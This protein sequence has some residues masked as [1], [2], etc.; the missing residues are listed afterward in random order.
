MNDMKVERIKRKIRKMKYWQRY[1]LMDWLNCWYA[2]EK[3]EQE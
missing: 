1:E 2:D 3:A